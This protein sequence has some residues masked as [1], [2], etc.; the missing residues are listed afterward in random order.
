MNHD[1]YMSCFQMVG[2]T[3]GK[4]YAECVYHEAVCVMLRKGGVSYSK[5]V[6]LA[7]KFLDTV[8]GNVRADLIIDNNQ[9]VIECK[10]TEA[11]LKPSFVSQLVNYMEITGHCNGYLVNFNQ[12]PQKE[13]VEVIF[14][15]KHDNDTYQA[16]SLDSDIM[17]FDKLGRQLKQA[18]L[19]QVQS[20]QPTQQ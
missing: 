10:A 13:M 11:T 9:L 12:H 17:L 7:I 19:A 2:N 20:T 1:Q 16:V 15:K 4:G 8:V 3:L 18:Q 5:E 6:P 14:V